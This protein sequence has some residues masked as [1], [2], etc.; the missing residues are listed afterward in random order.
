MNTAVLTF[1][2]LHDITKITLGFYY[3]KFTGKCKWDYKTLLKQFFLLIHSPFIF[4]SAAS[5]ISNYCLQWRIP[6][7]LQV[8]QPTYLGHTSSVPQFNV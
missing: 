5:S 4:A 2:E 7:V 8:L 6:G 1:I 3:T